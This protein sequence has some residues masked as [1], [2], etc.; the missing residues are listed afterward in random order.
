[1]NFM[2]P[3]W[4][5]HT[6]E[7]C[8]MTMS[9]ALHFP[10][11]SLHCAIHEHLHSPALATP[12]RTSKV[13]LILACP[14]ETL[15][16][17]ER[18]RLTVWGDGHLKV[19]WSCPLSAQVLWLQ[20]DYRLLLSPEIANLI[21]SPAVSKCC[22]GQVRTNLFVTP[23]PQR[24]KELRQDLRTTVCNEEFKVSSKTELVSALHKMNRL[25]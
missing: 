24:L 10:P 16:F 3:L 21:P 15:P 8:T 18:P 5:K 25:P 17:K 9:N 14:A 22:L 12:V 23:L 7:I 2:L 4:R 11:L 19:T 6:Q 13:P 1:M 20:L